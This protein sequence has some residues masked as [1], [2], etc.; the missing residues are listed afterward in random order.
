M[1]LDYIELKKSSFFDKVSVKDED[2]QAAYQKEIANLAEQRR[3][4]HILIEVNDKTTDA[5]AKARIEEIQQRVAKGEDFA[6]LAKE[7]LRI[8]AR[9]PKAVTWVT[10]ARVSMT[11][12]SKTRCTR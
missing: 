2:L 3:A 7:F 12:P 10:P 6:A 1:V 4:A 11:R 9:P 5:Q 8:R